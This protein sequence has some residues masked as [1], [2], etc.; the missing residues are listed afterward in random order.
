MDVVKRWGVKGGGGW[1]G[2][3]VGRW[4]GSDGTTGE[5]QVCRVESE[6]RKHF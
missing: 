1:V 2:D 6:P 5:I 4:G 3:E